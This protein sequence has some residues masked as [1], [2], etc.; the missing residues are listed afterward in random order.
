VTE[1]HKRLAM[2]FFFALIVGAMAAVAIKMLGEGLA[3]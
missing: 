3:N 2:V 1:G